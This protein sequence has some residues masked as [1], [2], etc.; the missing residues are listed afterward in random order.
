[1]GF[2]SEFKGLKVKQMNKG[3]VFAEMAGFKK[4]F[5]HRRHY[6]QRADKVAVHLQNRPSIFNTET[7]NLAAWAETTQR[8]LQTSV[9]TRRH[10]E[11]AFRSPR[12]RTATLCAASSNFLC[13]HQIYS[14]LIIFLCSRSFCKLDT[15][16]LP[17]S[18]KPVDYFK[19]VL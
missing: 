9:S 5:T 6:R 18:C 19:L 11:H 13:G 15:N 3:R 4:G 17:I 14:W 12:Y 16:F 1:M 7:N 10:V 2:N 8:M